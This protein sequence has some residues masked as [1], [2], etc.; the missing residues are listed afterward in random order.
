M[1]LLSAI[2]QINSILVDW[3]SRRAHEEGS[4][5]R[6]SNTWRKKGDDDDDRC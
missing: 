3:E 4:E 6:G 5:N 1:K 2:Y